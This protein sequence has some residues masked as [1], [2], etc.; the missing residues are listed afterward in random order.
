VKTLLLIHGAWHGAWCWYKVIDRL[1]KNYNVINVNL[2]SH[3]IDEMSPTVV[4]LDTYVEYVKDIIGDKTVSIVAH[5]MGGIIL[6]SLCE[7]IPDQIEKAIYLSAFAVDD[8]KSMKDYADLDTESITGQN[9]IFGDET[10]D[11]KRDSIRQCFYNECKEEY[12]TLAE[13]CLTVNPLAPFGQPV[14]LGMNYESVDKYYIKTLYDNSISY[15][16]QEIMIENAGIDISYMI[17]TDH[18]SFF[19]KPRKLVRIINKVML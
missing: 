13:T 2:P 4:T 9:L 10:V 1:E 7:L 19:S 12:V 5:S 11:I 6:S 17:D 8:G 15:Y 3:H 14:S 16:L 18:S